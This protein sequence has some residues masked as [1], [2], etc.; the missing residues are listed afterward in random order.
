MD[1]KNDFLFRDNI[2]EQITTQLLCPR[3]WTI[4]VMEESNQY[5]YFWQNI[6]FML[7]YPH[8]SVP[9]MFD[10]LN[11]QMMKVN[12]N[13]YSS[14]TYLIASVFHCMPDFNCIFLSYVP[15][16]LNTSLLEWDSLAADRCVSLSPSLIIET[17]LSWLFSPLFDV[18][19]FGIITVFMALTFL[20]QRNQTVMFLWHYFFQY[21]EIKLRCFNF[22]C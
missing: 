2:L 18:A 5:M 9:C 11:I 19:G 15:G 7:I 21:S 4:C 3:L 17:C 14:R 12:L 1:C 10:Y 22:S 16:C 8:M 6:N 13:T 20:M